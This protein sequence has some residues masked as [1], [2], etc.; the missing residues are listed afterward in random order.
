M[1]Y[2]LH[3]AD[4]PVAV[5]WVPHEGLRPKTSA[6]R[7]AATGPGPWKAYWVADGDGMN[8][9]GLKWLTF[10]IKGDASQ[11]LN[12]HLMDHH[13][14]GEDALMDEP[15]Y[16]APVPLIAGG[17]LK[18]VTAAYQKVR[19]PLEKLLPKGTYFLRWHTAG[20]GLSAPEGARPATYHVDL[21]QVEP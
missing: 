17:Y 10:Y 18:A 12:V 13:R 6:L 1:R 9:A 7:F 2:D 11:E 19:I 5:N 3:R 8:C 4:G 21:I 14:V 15:H 16:S 20:F